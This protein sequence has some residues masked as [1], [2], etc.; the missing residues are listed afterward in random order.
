[1]A[2]PPLGNLVRLEPLPI[3][4][5]PAHP[6]FDE[7]TPNRRSSVD[8][9][10]G[11]RPSLVLFLK[12][13]L[14]QATSFVDDVLPETFKEDGNQ[15]TSAPATA[16]VET[17]R[18]QISGQDIAAIPWQASPISRKPPGAIVASGEAWFARRSR[19]ANRS[20]E[21]TAAFGEFERGLMDNPS[22]AERQYTP[23]VLDARKVLD[24]DEQIATV[25]HGMTWDFSQI[26]MSIY[27]MYHHIPWPLGNRA[28]SIV[29][30]TAK[31]GPSSFIVVRIPVDI[32]TLPL[33]FYSNGRHAR[34]GDAT[35]KKNI[36]AGQYVSIERLRVLPDE[37]IEW[38]MAVSS[39][40][41]GSLPMSVQKMALP[42]EIA[43][44]VGLCIKWIGQRRKEAESTG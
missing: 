44:D 4:L 36:V 16:K 6:A 22:E 25:T 2:T 12:E 29:V 23:D 27:E 43:K 13:A 19:H 37:N 17:L 5:L 10:T 31:T 32:T 38:I 14:E 26:R 35:Q 1:M 41:K 24:W 9:H 34:E 11:N 28:F 30:I 42:G 33:A 7:I 20:E 8:S 39:D 18:R 21:G 15:K 3:N 40:A